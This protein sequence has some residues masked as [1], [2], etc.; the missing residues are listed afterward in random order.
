MQERAA[1]LRQQLNDAAHRYYVLDE[2]LIPDA[3]YDRMF[4][5]LL[6]LETQHP[7]LLTPDSPTQRVGG[8]GPGQFCQRPTRGAHAQHSHRNR[9]R[10]Q[11]C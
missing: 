8:Q 6:A 2:P 4:Q 10:S 1:F 5:E 7:E 9:Y 11:R 3:E